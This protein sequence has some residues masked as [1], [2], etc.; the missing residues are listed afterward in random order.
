M[1]NR[2]MLKWQHYLAHPSRRQAHLNWNSG[3]INTF[4]QARKKHVN[5]Q[6]K[7]ADVETKLKQPTHIPK[8]LKQLLENSEH[9]NFYH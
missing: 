2:K 8:S 7:Q 9:P 3:K 1:A 4:Y 5:V 6:D